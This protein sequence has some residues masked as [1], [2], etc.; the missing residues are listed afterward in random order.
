M[1]CPS[2]NALQ[3]DADLICR[4][5]GVLL[6]MSPEEL[7]RVERYRLSANTELLC[8]MFTDISGFTSI[9]NRSLTQSQKILAIHMALTQAIVEREKGGEVVNTAGDGI[10]A[11]FS[12]PATATERA[13]EMHAAI[14]HYHQGLITGGYL[15]DALKRAKMPSFPSADDIE[16]GIHI[17]LH[18][19]LVTRG[20]RTSRDVFGHNVNIACRLC[21]LA[22]K[23]QVY[24]TEAVY[25]NARLILGNREDLEWQVWKEQPIRGLAEPM[26]VVAVGQQPYN[27]ILPPRGV[28]Q[29]FQFNKLFGKRAP[30][31]VPAIVL[32]V[33][34]IGAAVGLM[35]RQQ[36]PRIV[37]APPVVTGKSTVT[38]PPTSLPP[39]VAA[40]EAPSVNPQVVPSPAPSPLTTA[41]AD[42]SAI[43]AASSATNLVTPP[44]SSL[45]PPTPVIPSGASTRAVTLTNGQHTI[46][47]TIHFSREKQLCR[48][49]IELNQKV[50]D[51]KA[52]LALLVDG[53]ND[54]KYQALPSRPAV[55]FLLGM[56]GPATQPR[57]LSA[58]LLGNDGKPDAPMP[59]EKEH[60]GESIFD[61]K[62]NVTIWQFRLPFSGG[63]PDDHDETGFKIEFRPSG[64]DGPVYVT[65]PD[66]ARGKMF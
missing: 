29:P 31:V 9:A 12:N 35:L 57:V 36:T 18:L 40:E 34:L 21:S 13:L 14:H 3:E 60:S 1:R 55:D 43:N 27:A 48:F 42:A 11:V 39:L 26:T 45:P 37:P 19:G 66:R 22:G 38:E 41:N 8:V 4:K 49:D 7:E 54:G 56:S 52:E 53:N 20:G 6:A 5:C 32:G 62:R 25:D 23:G 15:T 50:E 58:R 61:E 16:Y 2:C 24:M 63:G 44:D 10:L 47:A 17:G 30:V 28:R 51:A 65:P 33:A 59:N 64:S 46:A